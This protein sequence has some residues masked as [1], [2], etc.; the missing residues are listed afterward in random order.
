[1][2]VGLCPT[3]KAEMLCDQIGNAHYVI[4]PRHAPLGGI[5]GDCDGEGARVPIAYPDLDKRF[6]EELGG[7]V[8]HYS[9]LSWDMKIDDKTI[10]LNVRF[11]KPMTLADLGGSLPTVRLTVDGPP[12]K[13][14]SAEGGVDGK[15]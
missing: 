11:A 12:F 4:I 5:T 3:C 14:Y 2:P 1:M 9:T 8:A 7:L 10:S 6:A 15:E 13:I